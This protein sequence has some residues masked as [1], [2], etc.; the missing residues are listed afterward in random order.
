MFPVTKAVV[1]VPVSLLSFLLPPSRRGALLSASLRETSGCLTVSNLVHQKLK[2]THGNSCSFESRAS[3]AEGAP[4][5]TLAVYT[6]IDQKSKENKHK[7]RSFES[8]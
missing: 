2:K 7:S 5:G 4:Q 3:E 1:H 6:P 8:L